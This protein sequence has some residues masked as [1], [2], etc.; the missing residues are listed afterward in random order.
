M[1][2]QRMGDGERKTAERIVNLFRMKDLSKIDSRK[3]IQG[4]ADSGK[5]HVYTFREGGYLESSLLI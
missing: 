1:V 5:R 3:E 4:S 2:G